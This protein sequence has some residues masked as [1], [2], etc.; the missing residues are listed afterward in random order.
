MVIYLTEA[1]V[2]EQWI[3]KAGE[4][5]ELGLTQ[6]LLCSAGAAEGRSGLGGRKVVAVRVEP[7]GGRVGGVRL[8]FG[9]FLPELPV[10]SGQK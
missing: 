9:S 6:C 4:R 10:V 7:G 8:N 3:I 5:P 1:T 2:G